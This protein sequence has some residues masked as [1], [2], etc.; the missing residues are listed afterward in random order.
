M[1]GLLSS[2][3]PCMTLTACFP[4]HTEFQNAGLLLRSWNEG[5]MPPKVLLHQGTGIVIWCEHWRGFLRSLMLNAL[6]TETDIW[7]MP[8][9]II[10]NILLHD[11]KSYGRSWGNIN[12]GRMSS[13]GFIHGL[14][15]GNKR[16]PL[17]DS[18]ILA[19]KLDVC[20]LKHFK[21][22]NQTSLLWLVIIII[23]LKHKCL[24]LQDEWY[25]VLLHEEARTWPQSSKALQF[26]YGNPIRTCVRCTNQ[27]KAA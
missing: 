19:V 2:Q 7:R 8:F 5:L 12:W 13:V 18:T 25:C 9:L 14:W 27:D 16:N 10:Q 6:L 23:I 11:R 24:L 15:L 21:G 4:V 22:D 3:V 20:F 17:P 1:S 26:L